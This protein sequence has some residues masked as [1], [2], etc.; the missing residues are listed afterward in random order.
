MGYT[1]TR[2][3]TYFPTPTYMLATHYSN[4]ISFLGDA[5][6]LSYSVLGPF[7]EESENHVFGVYPP[8]RKCQESEDSN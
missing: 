5:N 8:S 2:M 1:W 4:L 6:C 3:Q 7:R